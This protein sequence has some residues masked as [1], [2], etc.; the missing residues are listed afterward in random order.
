ML[1]W[2]FGG[3]FKKELKSVV[4]IMEENPE[5]TQAIADAYRAA[6][7]IEDLALRFKK[8]DEEL[9]RQEREKNK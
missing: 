3:I 1:R 5:M 8:E 7:N 9:A 6:E 4:K 2:L